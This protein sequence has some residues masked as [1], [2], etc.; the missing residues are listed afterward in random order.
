MSEIIERLWNVQ[1]VAQRNLELLREDLS[2]FTE[3]LRDASTLLREVGWNLD[4]EDDLESMHRAVTAE[5][6]P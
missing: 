3:R 6:E 4:T 5:E 1:K 2:E